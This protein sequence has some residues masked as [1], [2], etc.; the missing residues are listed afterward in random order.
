MTIFMKRNDT[1]PVLELQ[2]IDAFDGTPASLAF[3]TDIKLLIKKGRDPVFSAPMT[4]IDSATGHV[5][6]EWLLGDLTV[7]GK[8]RLEVQVQYGSPDLTL[9]FPNDS[10]LDFHVTE[11]LDNSPVAP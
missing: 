9:T 4:I 5:A 10:Y 11:D 3:A 6:Y 8:F 7:L 1:L 2:L